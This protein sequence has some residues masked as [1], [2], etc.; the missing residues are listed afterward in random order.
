MCCLGFFSSPPPPALFVWY[1]VLSQVFVSLFCL[2]IHKIWT[3]TIIIIVIIIN[4]PPP[5]N[6]EYVPYMS[7]DLKEFVDESQRRSNRVAPVAASHN[8]D[9]P[10][11]RQLKSVEN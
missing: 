9:D 5:A 8:P 6:P 2:L 1:F 3:I 4:L 11:N 10:N 7:D